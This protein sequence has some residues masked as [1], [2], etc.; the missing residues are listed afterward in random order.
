MK[1]TTLLAGSLMAIAIQSASAAELGGLYGGITV[2]DTDYKAGWFDRDYFYHGGTF[3]HDDRSVAYG[4]QFGINS[5]RENLLLGAEFGYQS[6][7]SDVSTYYD[8]DLFYNNEISALY[9]L[10]VRAGLVQGGTTFYLTA[11]IAQTDEEH[12]LID[13]GGTNSTDTF[14]TE[15][16]M[17][18]IGVGIEHMIA[19][20]LSLRFEYQQGAGQETDEQ[21]IGNTESYEVTSDIRQFG[22]SVN[23]HF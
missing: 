6:M 5:V 8:N 3:E 10:K 15:R 12:Q 4:L 20:T 2:S 21:I 17:T 23:F 9:S 1:K 11:G 7:D 22:A 13:V 19:D 14:E 18:L 16:P